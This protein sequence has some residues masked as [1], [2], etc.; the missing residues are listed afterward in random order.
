MRLPE[1]RLQAADLPPGGA[2]D[3]DDL[4]AAG[5]SKA[6]DLWR[7]LAAES[8]K[9][10]ALLAE[11]NR[12]RKRGR[13]PLSPADLADL[14]ATV[15]E[16]HIDPMTRWWWPWLSQAFVAV[17]FV[18]FALIAWRLVN[19]PPVTREQVTVRRPAG[20]PAYHRIEKDDV[21]VASGPRD[22]LAA[23]DADAVV[24]RYTTRAL[25]DGEV[26]R[27]GDLR[28]GANV[29]ELNNRV[30]LAVP[31]GNVDAALAGSLPAVVTL[32]LSS[33]TGAAR[34]RH[35][36]VYLLALERE[37]TT[38]SAP[39]GRSVATVAVPRATLDAFQPLLGARS[40]T[41]AW[42]PPR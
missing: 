22:P 34:E 30:I 40:V 29:P 6:S 25:K 3:L 21:V 12:K 33:E 37:P 2:F 38:V 36:K 15:A 10:D 5:L 17:L 41:V 28:E 24:G 19:P 27:S 1:R 4:Q 26:V 42:D 32:L 35:E 13:R 8:W 18:T 20:L 14:V 16:R 39:T 7:R 23:P 31:V 9:L 11:L